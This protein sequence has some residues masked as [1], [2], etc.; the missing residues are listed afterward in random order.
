[1]VRRYI[2]EK[3]QRGAEL[4]GPAGAA[5]SDVCEP[6]TVWSE[7]GKSLLRRRSELVERSF[8]PYRDLIKWSLPLD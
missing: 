8:A 2:P 3:K 4:G 5:A 1:M 7:Y 6:A